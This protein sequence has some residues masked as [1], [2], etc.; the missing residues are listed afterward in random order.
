MFKN[1]KGRNYIS[2]VYFD[3]LQ[4]QELGEARFYQ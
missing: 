1:P 4:G 2:V 3:K